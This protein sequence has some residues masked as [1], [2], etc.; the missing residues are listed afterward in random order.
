MLDDVLAAFDAAWNEPDRAE[1]LRLLTRSLTD[2]AQLV[3]PSARFEG[4]EAIEARIAG[5]SK[6]FPGTRVKITSGIDEHNGFARYGWVIS[7]GDGTT[8]LDGID[9]VERAEDNRLRRVIMF[10]GALPEAT[11]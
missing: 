4:I 10:F 9:V 11:G 7:A 5:F 8:I 6:R 2:D 1:R 3:D